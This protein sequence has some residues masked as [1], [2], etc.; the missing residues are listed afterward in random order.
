MIG[1]NW[2]Y[3]HGIHPING[4]ASRK[5]VFLRRA[6]VWAAPHMD[7]KT[8][9]IIS[10]MVNAAL[11]PSRNP[12]NFS[13]NTMRNSSVEPNIKTQETITAAF[14]ALFSLINSSFIFL[15]LRFLISFFSAVFCCL[16]SL[17][18]FVIFLTF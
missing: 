2:A 12:L 13:W 4:K 11:T 15:F 6:D 1:T 5:C 18:S 8:M 10:S 7:P 3:N 14:I 9:N 16:Y 17:N